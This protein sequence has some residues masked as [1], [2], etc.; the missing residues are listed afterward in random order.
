[1]RWATGG[2]AVLVIPLSLLL[3]VQWPLRDWLH[4]YSRFANDAGQIVFA[5]YAAVAVTAASLT[6]SHLAISQH[7]AN[8]AQGGITWRHWVLL[9]CVAPWAVFLLWAA[10]PP[11][12][13]SV[14][15]LESFSEGLTPGYFMLRIALVLLAL[16][17]LVEVVCGVLATQYPARDADPS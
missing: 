6:R 11:M 15:Q 4:A 8:A 5:L 16:L 17:A 7:H 14:A 1:M 12:L 13:A 10:V 9:L 2:A 3:F